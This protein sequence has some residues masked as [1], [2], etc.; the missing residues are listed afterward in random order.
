MGTSSRLAAMT[1][2]C[3]L[4]SVL[5]SFSGEIW[6]F[7]EAGEVRK[8]NIHVLKTSISVSS[9]PRKGKHVEGTWWSCLLVC[10]VSTSYALNSKH[11]PEIPNFQWKE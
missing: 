8:N 2:V 11:V 6:D 9:P 4:H 7:A 3:A 10:L 5:S 1:T